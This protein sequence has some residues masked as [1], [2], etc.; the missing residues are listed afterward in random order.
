MCL[1]ML[2]FNKFSAKYTVF[3]VS[4]E[5]AI[6]VPYGYIQLNID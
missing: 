2:T 3:V 1:L 6:F 4:F 5:S